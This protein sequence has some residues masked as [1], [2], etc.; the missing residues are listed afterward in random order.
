MSEF[1]HITIHG[2]KERVYGTRVVWCDQISRSIKQE[3]NYMLGH[4]SVPSDTKNPP[5]NN[6]SIIY[7]T[8]YTEMITINLCV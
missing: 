6:S 2:C 7:H 4:E 8:P 1:T 5:F 3:H